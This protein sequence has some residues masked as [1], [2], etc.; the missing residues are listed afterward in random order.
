MPRVA[1]Q[2]E[3]DTHYG[4]LL[5]EKSMTNILLVT[6]GKIGEEMIKCLKAITK[7]EPPIKVLSISHDFTPEEIHEKIDQTIHNG[8]DANTKTLILIDIYGAT[9]FNQCAD[10]LKDDNIEVIA[11]INLPILIK[12]STMQDDLS[13][14]E[15]TN[16]IKE[17]GKKNIISAK[18]VLKRS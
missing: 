8:T 15:L 13:L 1:G 17:Y 12:L 5:T 4:F 14:S 9:H 7:E 11:G 16:Y 18:E 10:F 6:H 3:E 2:C